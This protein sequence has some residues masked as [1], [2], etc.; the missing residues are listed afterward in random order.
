[1]PGDCDENEKGDLQE[2][3][4]VPRYRQRNAREGG[5]PKDTKETAIQRQTNQNRHVHLHR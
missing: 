5:V 2:R 4:P 3:I 1:M